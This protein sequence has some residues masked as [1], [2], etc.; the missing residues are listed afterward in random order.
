VESNFTYEKDLLDSI[1]AQSKQAASADL[2]KGISQLPT[3]PPKGVES[4]V[5]GMPGV[6]LKVAA[7]L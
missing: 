6:P 1:E 5:K 3:A 7:P 2:E 4:A